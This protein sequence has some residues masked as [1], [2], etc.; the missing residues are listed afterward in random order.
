MYGRA[1]LP[2]PLPW[3]TQGDAAPS[4]DPSLPAALRRASIEPLLGSTVQLVLV[5]GVQV[6]QP[7]G[8]GHVR[9]DPA[10]PLG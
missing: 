7:W 9:A 6:S 1:G 2:I 4:S 3:G 10:I 5:E 8:W